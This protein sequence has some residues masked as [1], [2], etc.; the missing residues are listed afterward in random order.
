MLPPTLRRVAISEQLLS[1]ELTQAMKARDSQRV[2]VLR[3]VVAAAKNVKVERRVPTLEEADLVAIV[4]R[5]VKKRE[6]TEAYAD[7]AGRRDIVEQNRAERAILEAWVP[8]SL[9]AE[10]LEQTIRDIAAGSAGGALGGIMAALKEQFAGRYDGK[11]ASDIARRIL[12][13]RA[14]G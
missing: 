1:D 11:L 6:E 2:L 12:A 13:A 7:K 10:E 5:E 14:A 3:S 4:R 8:A 9:T